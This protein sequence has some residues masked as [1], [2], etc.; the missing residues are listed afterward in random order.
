MNNGMRLLNTSFRTDFNS[1]RLS[2]A[3]TLSHELAKTKKA[4]ELIDDGWTIVTEAIFKNGSRA[5]I[6]IPET[7]QVFE[8]LHSETEK[9]L[10]EKIKKYPQELEIFYLKSSEVLADE[11]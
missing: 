10:K 4:Y 5:D 9:M 7:L 2:T 6:F 1:V 3:N 8:I 11:H